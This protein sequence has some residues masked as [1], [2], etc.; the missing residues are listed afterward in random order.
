MVGCVFYRQLLLLTGK[1]FN[2]NLKSSAKLVL[3][4]LVAALQVRVQQVTAHPFIIYIW[5][6][7]R[8]K[9]GISP[10]QPETNMLNEHIF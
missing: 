8:K 5:W 3:I 7:W 10:L 6:R 1:K 9:S 4:Q 2:P